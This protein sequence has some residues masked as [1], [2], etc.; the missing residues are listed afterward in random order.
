MH[1]ANKKQLRVTVRNGEFLRFTSPRT[2]NEHSFRCT[3]RRQGVSFYFAF[4]LTCTRLYRPIPCQISLCLLLQLMLAHG[5]RDN[6][7]YK[8]VRWLRNPRSIPE[9]FRRF[10]SPPDRMCSSP[11]VPSNGYKSLSS[12]SESSWSVKLCVHITYSKEPGE[13]SRYTDQVTGWTIQEPWFACRKQQGPFF[14]NSRASL[15]HL[16]LPINWRGRGGSPGVKR[17]GS[18]ADN[19]PLSK[20]EDM[21]EWKNT[22]TPLWHAQWQLYLYR[23]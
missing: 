16:Q 5:W 8:E 19:S 6:S 12:R 2:N 11:N 10:L 21:N 14:R 4:P 23:C 13:G 3:R 20:T 9:E 7:Q 22:S 15:G 1:T 18:E 17:P